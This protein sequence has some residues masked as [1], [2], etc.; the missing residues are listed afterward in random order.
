M[1]VSP[2]DLMVYTRLRL[3]GLQPLCGTGVV[4]L[5]MLMAS[6]ALCKPRTADS[7]PAPGP[8]KFTSHSFMPRAIASRAA[9]WAATV[10]AK[11]EDLRDPAKFDF[12]ADDHEMTFPAKSVIA[13]I[14]LLNV[15]LTWAIPEGTLRTIFFFTLTCAFFGGAFCSCFAKGVLL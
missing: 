2:I 13:T 4:S 1:F 12:P 15:A 10:A 14:V 6:P 8:L 9:F 7:R 3:R 5:M 11:A